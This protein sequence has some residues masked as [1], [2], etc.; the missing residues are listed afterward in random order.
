MK[1]AL[2]RE[3]TLKGMTNWAAYSNFKENEKGS[4]EVG[5]KADFVVLSDDIMNVDVHAIPEI[6]AEKV[7]VGGAQVK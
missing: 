7:F 1:D 4:I 5:K 3:E 6:E 2:T